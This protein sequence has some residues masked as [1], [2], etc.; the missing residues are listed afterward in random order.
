MLV[1]HDPENRLTNAIRALYPANLPATYAET[2][3]RGSPIYSRGYV[4]KD[5]RILAGKTRSSHWFKNINEQHLEVKEAVGMDFAS[6]DEAH[7]VPKLS[8]GGAKNVAQKEHPNERFREQ[9]MM[10]HLL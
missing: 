1:F 9:Y 8:R 10:Q 2:F 7:K 4:P 5:A 6:V 3:W